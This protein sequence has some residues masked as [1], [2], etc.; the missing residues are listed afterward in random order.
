MLYTYAVAR[1]GCRPPQGLSGVAGAPVETVSEG[2]LAALV[3]RVPAADF[4][5]AALK[6][7][8]EELDWL[9]RTARA[10]RA[11]VDTAAASFCVLPLRLVTVH[12]DERGV[13]E[14]LSTHAREFLG[15]LEALDGRVEWGVKAYADEAGA[16]PPAAES[17]TEPPTGPA[18]APT[19]PDGPA[20]P[21]AAGSGRD[22]LR[23]RIAHRRARDAAQQ[24]ADDL[25]RTVHAELDR[26]A[27]RSRLHRPQD[28]RLSG[29]P[30]RNVL[31]GAYL[32]PRA[33]A[34]A[35]TA[36]VGKLADRSTGV[37]IELTGPWAP[38]SF[39]GP[40]EPAH[41]HRRGQA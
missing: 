12:R 29:V 38:Y 19:G 3:S 35:F 28:A 39:T 30:G 11:V 34:G 31:N 36:L 1:A 26:F 41:D 5:E 2:G 20:A 21:A 16:S 9:E 14:V 10:H 15:A 6:E 25:A 8:L 23:R 22:F 33:D 37:R 7:H 32:V 24:H 18:A 17:T 4:E 27:E 40:P 13:R